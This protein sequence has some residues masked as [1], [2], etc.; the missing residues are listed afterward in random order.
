[1]SSVYEILRTSELYEKLERLLD[2]DKI[3][4]KKQEEKRLEF[5]DSDVREYHRLVNSL[6]GIS[7]EDLKGYH[8]QLKELETEL[9]KSEDKL[10]QLDILREENKRLVGLIKKIVETKEY[11]ESLERNLAKY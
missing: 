2:L 10:S 8:G 11:L 6:S 5:G 4:H 9:K 1:M 3:I 7:I